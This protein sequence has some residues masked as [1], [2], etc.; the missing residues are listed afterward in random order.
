M[1]SHKSEWRWFCW[2]LRADSMGTLHTVIVWRS[3]MEF[4]FVRLSIWLKGRSG[5]AWTTCESNLRG[6]AHF[7]GREVSS[8]FHQPDFRSA[9]PQNSIRGRYHQHNSSFLLLLAIVFP[10]T[11]LRIFPAFYLRSLLL[12]VLIHI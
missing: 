2:F 7:V 6:K 3:L 11:S 8:I 1:R 4:N 9:R 10:P 12:V 5:F